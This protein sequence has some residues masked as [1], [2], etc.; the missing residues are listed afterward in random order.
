M[1]DPA[2]L[3][4]FW[5][6]FLLALV[7]PG[8]NWAVLA[9]TAIREGRKRALGTAVG[10]AGGEAVWACAAVFGV[11]ALASQHPWLAAGLRLGGGAFLLY[12]GLTALLAAARPARADV[13]GLAT[14]AT[15]QGPGVWRGVGLML[16]NPKAGVFWVS[17][18]S[19]FLGSSVSATT[20]AV[21]VTG[22][23]VLSLAWH[24]ALAW[25]LSA[26]AIGRTLARARRI[27]D[28]ALGTVLT[29]LGVKLL[30]PG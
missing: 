27:L 30:A 14:T 22:A 26:P 20:A 5:S 24:G 8:P 6:A 18:S 25:L 2:L 1:R 7:T 9:S 3:A 15:Q 29:A 21:A 19:L 4:A 10:L 16:L 17:L 11:S 28:A 13:G 12:L 23:V